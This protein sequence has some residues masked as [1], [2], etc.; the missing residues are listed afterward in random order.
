MTKLKIYIAGKITGL[1]K[2][3]YT[4]AFED[5]EQ[6]IKAMGHEPINPIKIVPQ[7]IT[8]DDQMHLCF[9]LVDISNAVMMLENWVDSPGATKELIRGAKQE[10]KI[11][12]YDEQKVLYGSIDP[13]D[14]S[15]DALHWLLKGLDIPSADVN[16]NPK[17]VFITSN[18]FINDIPRSII[19]SFEDK[20]FTFKPVGFE[21]SSD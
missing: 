19:R 15:R 20:G 21:V 16:P 8:Y 3:I 6:L 10:K 2:E 4:K 12:Y 13:P 17:T 1:E 7:S 14:Y 9:A 5:A 11:L 18:S